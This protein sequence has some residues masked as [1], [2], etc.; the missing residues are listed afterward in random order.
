MIWNKTFRSTKASDQS[1]FRAA[2]MTSDRSHA[3]TS[4]IDLFSVQEETGHSV[5]SL[6]FHDRSIDHKALTLGMDRMAQRLQTE[7]VATGRTVGLCLERSPELIISVLGILKA[8]AAYVPIDPTYP[9]ERIALML[10]DAQPPV[11][12]TDKA[13]QHL[14]KGTKAKVLLIE[15]IDLD[16]RTAVRRALPCNAGEPGLRA[17]HQ[18]QH[19]SAERCG[20]APCAADEPDPVATAHLRLEAKA[21]AR[22]S[23]RRSAST[24]ASRSSSPRSRKAEPWC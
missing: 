13:H 5:P 11:V 16:E 2:S 7:G 1:T 21:T 10:E 17:L 20:H 18:R 22:C 14:F 12:I 8:G 15:D 24:S 3:A 6:I 4:V 23:S 9:A 19:R